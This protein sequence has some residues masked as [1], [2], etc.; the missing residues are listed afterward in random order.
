MNTAAPSCWQRRLQF[1]PFTLFALLLLLGAD[2]LLACLRVVTQ[3]ISYPYELE[4]ME[5]G[6]L[7][8]VLRVL[9]GQTLYGGEPSMDFVPALYMPFYYYLSALSVTLFGEGLPALRAAS[10][11]ASCLTMLMVFLIVSRTAKSAVAGVLGVFFYA[12]MFRH[13]GGWFDVARVDSLWTF[14]LA[15]AL[16]MLLLCRDNFSPARLL[17]LALLSVLACFTK[18]ASLFVAPFVV[19]AMLFWCG[20]RVVLQ[21]LSLCLLLSLPLL[22]FLQA[23]AGEDWIFYTTQMAST[24]GI[25]WFGVRRF[26]E[27][28]L[29]AVPAMLQAALAGLYLLPDTLRGRL[30]WLCLFGGFFFVSLLSRAYAGAYFNV[31]MPVYFMVACCAALG[32]WLLWQRSQVSI[33]FLLLTACVMAAV[34]FDF[35]R[36]RLDVERLLPTAQSRTN[37]EWLL[38][39][40]R[41]VP[42]RVCVTSHGYLGWLAGKDFC[43]HNTQVTDLVTGSSAERAEV[44][45]ADARAR[46][47]SGYYRV[48]M[49]DREKDL[50]DLG[51]TMAEIPYVVEPLQYPD[52]EITFAVNGRSPRLWLQYNSFQHNKP[53][54]LQ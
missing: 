50:Q 44:L 12:Y 5:G 22:G 46:I 1:L 16:Y 37:T 9:H 32:V 39:K 45:R 41:A 43:A 49:L 7:Q 52:G 28:F 24:H 19:L 3:R 15:A 18:Q 26:F 53:A 48:I 8:Q 17:L 35:W 36:F 33:C 14:L 20:A 2:A 38:A 11:L 29:Q 25:T 31:L 30:G 13:T 34:S 21:Y 51:L 42:G 54:Q 47:L 10:L 27:I 4:W 6:V 40:I 23:Q